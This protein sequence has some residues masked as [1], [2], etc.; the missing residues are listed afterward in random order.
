MTIQEHTQRWKDM[1]NRHAIGMSAIIQ[2]VNEL[3]KAK[4]VN[5]DKNV[6]GGEGEEVGNDEGSK[7][8]AKLKGLGFANEVAMLMTMHKQK[9]ADDT[10]CT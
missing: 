6:K 5:C 7:L 4:A 9:K 3:P 2:K 1:C 8:K 10:A